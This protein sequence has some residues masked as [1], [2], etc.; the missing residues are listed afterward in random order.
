[1][2]GTRGRRL[3]EPPISS[4]R[5]STHDNLGAKWHLMGGRAS[6]VR[7]R[8]NLWGLRAS[9]V[10]EL[11]TAQPQ[12]GPRTARRGEGASPS[13]APRREL[14]IRRGSAHSC[15][16]QFVPSLCF[17]SASD[18]F[19]GIQSTVERI[20]PSTFSLWLLPQPQIFICDSV[21]LV[22]GV[23]LSD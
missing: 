1:M 15:S 4:R 6:L 14:V 19:K 5:V 10:A 23:E 21:I 16:F 2:S 9:A 8:P 11:Y 3:L 20:L 13:P 7:L 12:R 22:P 17:C 18:S